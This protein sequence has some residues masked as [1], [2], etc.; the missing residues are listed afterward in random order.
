VALVAYDGT[1][2]SEFCWPPLTVS[3]QPVDAMARVAVATVL[4]PTDAPDH[5]QLPTE[6]VLR[7]SCGCPWPPTPTRQ[8]DHPCP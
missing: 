2:D 7:R 4:D 3:R 8:D 1:A 6:L 5:Q